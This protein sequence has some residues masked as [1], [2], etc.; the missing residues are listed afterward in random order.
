VHPRL[1]ELRTKERELISE[2]SGG[3]GQNKNLAGR[4]AGLDDQVCVCAH[5]FLRVCVCECMCK[6]M[7]CALHMCAWPVQ[8]PQAAFA[9]ISF[10]RCPW[11]ERSFKT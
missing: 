7:M 9:N 3:Q 10:E 1:F 11:Q 5:V 4:L 8:L 2:I 6:Q